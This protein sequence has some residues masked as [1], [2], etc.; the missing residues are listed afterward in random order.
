MICIV[1]A[2]VQRILFPVLDVNVLNATHEQFQF[3]FVEDFKQ[4][5]R[6]NRT[7]TLQKGGHLFFDAG[8]KAPLDHQ[9]NNL[10][11]NY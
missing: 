9:S 1:V 2:L 4:R 5:Q 6:T 8:H 7:E 10:N 11:N 3:V